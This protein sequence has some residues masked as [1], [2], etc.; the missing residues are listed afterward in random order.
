MLVFLSLL[1]ML[2]LVLCKVSREPVTPIQRDKSS[3][4]WVDKCPPLLDMC[5][6][7]SLFD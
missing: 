5:I 3:G 4:N 7:E 1:I 6:Y 2:L